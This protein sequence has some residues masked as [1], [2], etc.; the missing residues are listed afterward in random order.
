[1]VEYLLNYKTVIR[2]TQTEPLSDISN[3]DFIHALLYQC[4]YQSRKHKLH[5]AYLVFIYLMKIFYF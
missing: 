4:Q 2:E 3:S 5:G 1:M